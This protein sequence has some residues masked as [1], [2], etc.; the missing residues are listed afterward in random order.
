[1]LILLSLSLTLVASCCTSPEIPDGQVVGSYQ[2]RLATACEI[3]AEA[4]AAEAAE[5]IVATGGRVGR[6]DSRRFGTGTELLEASLAGRRSSSLDGVA[7]VTRRARRLKVVFEAL[8]EA[9]NPALRGR[10]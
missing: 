10:G 4:A 3:E 7:L 5:C 6:S 9:A 8:E 1:M 2:V